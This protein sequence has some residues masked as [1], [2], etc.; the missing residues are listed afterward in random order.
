MF[1]GLFQNVSL[2]NFIVKSKIFKNYYFPMANSD[3]GLSLG[4]ALYIKHL[5]KKNLEN[6]QILRH[7]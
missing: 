1:G 4:A 3:A 2:N 5:I 7:I 6:S